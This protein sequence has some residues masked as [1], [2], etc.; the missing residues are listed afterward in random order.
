MTG[1]GPCPRHEDMTG[2][3]PCPRP[4]DHDRP[5]SVSQARGPGQASA[6]PLSPPLT[7]LPA[8]F[9]FSSPFPPTAAEFYLV[10]FL[11]P[12]T[13][14]EHSVTRSPEGNILRAQLLTVAT[15]CRESEMLED[16]GVV[17]S[18]KPGRE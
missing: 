8:L 18:A 7:V 10:C 2:Q 14:E 16:S 17:S 15:N 3:R 4:K 5:A 12:V 1:Q 11:I 9:H 13:T 6:E